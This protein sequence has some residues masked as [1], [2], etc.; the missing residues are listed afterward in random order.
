[1][2]VEREFGAVRFQ[3]N[4]HIIARGLSFKKSTRVTQL[5]ITLTIDEIQAV[6]ASQLPVDPNAARN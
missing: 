2:D 1:M 5:A 4:W 6:L 3:A